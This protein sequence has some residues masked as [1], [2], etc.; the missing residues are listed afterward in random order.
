MGKD[1]LR[2]FAEFLN[3]NNCFSF[4]FELKGKWHD[5]YFKNSNPIV[6][7]LGCGKGE[8]TVNLAEAFP[9]KNFIGID[10][11]SNRMWK[12]ASQALEKKMQNVA[13]VRLMIDKISQIFN[14]NEVDEIWITFPDP[15][16]K[17]RHAKHRLTHP[18]FLKQ[19][20]QVLKPNGVINLK[21]DDD[22]LFA[23]TQ[24]VLQQTNTTPLFVEQ[25]VYSSTLVPHYVKNIKTH[26]EKLFSAKG[27]TIKYM[28][29]CLPSEAEL[30]LYLKQ[31]K[32]AA[33]AAKK[34]KVNAIAT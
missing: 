13:F 22:D 21:T 19:Y 9:N 4:P 33:Q 6:V 1:K 7:E 29:F 24:H 30:D 27:H 31:E 10:L 3:F 18:R 20:L 11:K 5:L 8:Y 14:G 28:Q 25:N 23:F 2:K 12:G 17:N 34:L 16:P 15:F 32:Q 26:Y